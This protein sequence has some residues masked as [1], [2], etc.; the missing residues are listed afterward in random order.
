[1]CPWDGSRIY[2]WKPVWE[3]EG[4]WVGVKYHVYGKWYGQKYLKYVTN[5]V[6][7]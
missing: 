7:K 4:I 1:M 5:I 3:S 2:F 6:Q